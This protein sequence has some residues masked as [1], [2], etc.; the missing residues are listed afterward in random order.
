MFLRKGFVLGSVESVSAV[1]PLG[2]GEVTEMEDRVNVNNVDVHDAE[3]PVPD[4]DIDLSH[5]P[6]DQRA[7]A[8]QLLDEER[9]VFCVGKED[10][11]DCPDL[12][13][14]LN[15]T[16]NVPV[17][18]P[19]RQIP[20]PLYEEV[21]NFLN[22]LI[23]NNWVRESKSSYSSPIVCVRKKDGGLR[24]CID[25]R[26]LNKKVVPDKQPIPR[27]QEI[28]DGLGGQEYFSTLDM[29]K[30]YHQGYVGEEFRHYTA[31]STPWGLYEWIRVPKGISNAPPAFQRFINQTL[32]NLRDKVCVAYLDDILIYA[33]TFEEHV[34]NLR[35]VLQRLKSQGIKLRADKYICVYSV[36]ISRSFGL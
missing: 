22:D 11:G 8:Q 3:N 20:R 36:W 4:V 2:S 29:A 30:A 33:R 27:I 25:Y 35:L 5:L 14:E 1:V 28:F 24:L 9:D 19:H 7:L 17:V 10:H 13:M 12:V 16:D 23:A 21:K 18:V 26:A 32:A 15:L 34:Y 6:E 31:F